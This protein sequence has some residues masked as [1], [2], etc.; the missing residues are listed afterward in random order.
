MGASIKA[1]W[2]KWVQKLSIQKINAAKIMISIEEMKVGSAQLV[3]LS[4]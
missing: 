4:W 1:G 3:G 2:G